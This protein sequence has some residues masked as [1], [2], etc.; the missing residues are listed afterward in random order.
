MS[1]AWGLGAFPLQDAP[2]WEEGAPL[3]WAWS[4]GPLEP[5]PASKSAFR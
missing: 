1:L 2:A 3:C 4:L 5:A